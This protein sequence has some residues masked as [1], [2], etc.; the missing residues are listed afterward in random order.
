MNGAISSTQAGGLMFFFN[1]AMIRLYRTM[2]LYS[3]DI[4]LQKQSSMLW[5]VQSDPNNEQNLHTFFGAGLPLV[6][7]A[8]LLS[9]VFPTN[10]P[11]NWTG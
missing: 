7:T 9:A 10:C 1:A 6:L 8:P 4:G 3:G 2:G 5:L 11:R